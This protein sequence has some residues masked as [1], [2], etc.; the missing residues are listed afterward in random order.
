[1]TEDAE[2]IP[3]A[4]A[5]SAEGSLPSEMSADDANR[6]FS[7]MLSDVARDCV[8]AGSWMIGHIKANVRSGNELLSISS[9]TDDGNVRIRSRFL[10]SVKDYS[11]T[12][13]VI[14]Y[15]VE[16][17][18][19]AEILISNVKKALGGIG[20]TVH[21]EIGCE[22]PECSDPACSDKDHRRIIK[23]I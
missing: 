2:M 22:D 20:M 12:V 10:N 9:T 1:M 21:S 5:A 19:V 6:L 15:G 13:N 16:R 14:V 17:H 18:I 23:I 8:K 4:I 3:S 11:M 7:Q